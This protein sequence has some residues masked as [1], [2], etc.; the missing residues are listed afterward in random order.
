MIFW[1]IT[2]KDDRFT[3]ISEY[4]IN[5]DN[6][7]NAFNNICNRYLNKNIKEIKTFDTRSMKSYEYGDTIIILQR[8]RTRD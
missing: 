7:N 6:A 8:V 2:E 4:Y 5:E 1:H 3:Y